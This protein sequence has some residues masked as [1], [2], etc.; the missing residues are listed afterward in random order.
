MSSPHNPPSIAFQMHNQRRRL[1][2]VL[3]K[4]GACCG[5]LGLRRAPERRRVLDVLIANG[6][7]CKI[8]RT[9]VESAAVC[10]HCSARKAM[11]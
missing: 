11:S 3:S 10:P 9:V 7:A 8:E 1:G 5:S 6:F 4:V 2:R